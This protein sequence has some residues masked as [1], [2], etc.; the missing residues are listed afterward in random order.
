MV[1]E[2]TVHGDRQG[3]A[4]PAKHVN[5]LA[6][7]QPDKQGIES[8]RRHVEVQDVE[9]LPKSVVARCL[10]QLEQV[11][12]MVFCR[13][14]AARIPSVCGIERILDFLKRRRPSREGA[15]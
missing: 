11:F 12:Q 9:P 15:A 7:Y 5:P 1:R 6:L 14:V 3:V 2:A 13:H 4:D 10:T 8:M